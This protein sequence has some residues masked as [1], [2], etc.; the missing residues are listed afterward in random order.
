MRQILPFRPALPAFDSGHLAEPLYVWVSQT[1]HRG[2]W[3]TAIT[4]RFEP[5]AGYCGR[6][7]LSQC[8]VRDGVCLVAVQQLVTIEDA[9]DFSTHGHRYVDQDSGEVVYEPA[10]H[11]P[12]ED[13]DR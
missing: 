11:H 10:I 5:E 8:S 13:T 9:A 4:R 1:R 12:A 7:P 2:G 3:V 6:C